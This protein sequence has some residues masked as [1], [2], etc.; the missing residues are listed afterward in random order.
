[1]KARGG[2]RARKTSRAAPRIQGGVPLDATALEAIER[3][4]RVLARCGGAPIDILRAFSRACRRIPKDLS[5]RDGRAQRELSDASH[6]LTVWF[7][8]P[9]YLDREGAPIR[10]PFQGAAP[11]LHALIRR[12]DRS[13]KPEE[14]LRYLLRTK[15]VQRIGSRYVPRSRVLSLRGSQGPDSFRNLRSLVGI[16]RT[17]EHNMKPKSEVPSWFEYFA[18]NPRFPIS[19]RG[20][21]DKH[22]DEL[23]MEFLHALDT[24]M[25]R[26]E[27]RRQPGERT[28]RMGVGIY[29]F[30]DDE[31]DIQAGEKVT[32]ARKTSRPIRKERRS[33]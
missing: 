33:A 15:A 8:D 21:F 12:I 23:G 20:A 5:E 30:E 26:R 10:L 25:H 24:E 3:F 14:V 7:S 17:L 19:A 31:L 1:M 32:V 13:V 9:L 16:L 22:L 4:V 2:R 29:R 18:E 11:S 6:I 28:V 27:L